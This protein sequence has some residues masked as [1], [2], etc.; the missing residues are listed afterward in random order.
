MRAGQFTDAYLPILNGV[1]TL[2]HLF[3]RTLE[4]FGHEPYVFT[5]GYT[6]RADAEPNIVRSRGWP[7][8]RTGYYAGLAHS[9]RAWSIA[10]TMDMLHTHHPFQSGALAARLSREVNRPLVFTNHTRYDLYA[11]HYLPFL[12]EPAARA[13]LGVWMRRFARRCDL[14]VAVS[15]ATKTMLEAFRVTA[16]IDIIPNGIEL[17][18]FARAAPAARADLGLPPEAFVLMYV[19]RLG[20][21]KNL[22]ALLDAFAHAA[23]RA[24]NV[25]LALVG[26]GP[27]EAALRQRARELNRVD[28]IRF[29]G[30]FPNE[31]IP[32]ILGTANAFVTAS[33]TEGHPL[34]I[35]EALASGRPAL[36]FD[37]P[38]IRETIV[39]GENGLLTQASPSALGDGMAC[40]ASDA[41]LCARLGDGAQRSAQQYSIETAT[42]RI[43]NHYERLI[44]E[45]S[46]DGALVR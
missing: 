12:P 45:K 27:L 46:L 5:F 20:P 43:L 37:V 25:A 36:G 9:R 38:G 29:L 3:K 26:G 2:I 42:R 35:V 41:Q 7:I 4:A 32:S 1:S 11:R 30:T 19:G 6:G 33:V 16:P 28:R 44:R 8:G 10:R 17:D 14:I 31:K 18:R 15:A 24:P 39:D 22:V 21:E 40:L 23:R 34:T 13:F